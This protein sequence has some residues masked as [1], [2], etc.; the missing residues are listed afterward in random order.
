MN[1][2]AKERIIFM[3][4]PEMVLILDFGGQHSQLLARRVREFEVYC[5]VHPCNLSVEQ[6]KAMAPAGIILT[7]GPADA[8]SPA[9]P[10]FDLEILNLGV[11]VLGICYG[12]LL[13]AHLSGGRVEEGLA[14]E[15]G[16]ATLT[17]TAKSTLLEGVQEQSACWIS[18][19][20][21]VSSLPEP[22]VI[23]GRTDACIAAMENAEKRLYGV[24][25]HP[26]VSHTECGNTVIK[27]FLFGIC[28]LSGGWTMEKYAE[29]AI[30]EIRKTVGNGQ[31]LL[32]LS[33]G[34][35]SSVCAALVSKAVG[36]QLT[37]VFVDHGLMR[38]DEGDEVEEAF[39]GHF[40]L[41][42]L[43]A[44]EQAHFLS[45]LKGVSD[46]E[47]KRK[48]IGREFIRVFEKY[49]KQIGTVDFLC[50]G[51][52]YPDVIESGPGQAAVIK[53]HHNVG[54]LPDVVNFRE[55]IE[56]LR[57][58]FKDEVRKLGLALG[59]PE[60]LVWRQPFPGPGLAIR[61]MGEITED[62]LRIVRESDA[63]FRA[64]IAAAGLEKSIHQYFTVLT[65]TKT[66]GMMDNAR[67]FENVL[68]LRAV[69]TTDF[70]TADWVRIPYEVLDK[71]SSRIISEVPGTNRIV[72][73]ITSKP[74]ATIEWE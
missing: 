47:Q 37:C 29:T 13:I 65:E 6:V 3:K 18:H 24:Q 31:V 59:L 49:A 43:R 69:A 57:P 16:R 10:S 33:G 26:E 28:G 38:K 40:D 19:S 1:S 55:I 63:I 32:A 72:Y 8:T 14:Q 12:H 64:E 7:G 52:I 27:N 39:K 42:F 56:P 73:D 41:N 45:H 74:P 22:F 66:V 70:M 21:V 23:T 48:I 2:Y 34:V 25:F 9:A 36:K 4:K 51:T 30:E 53:S 17:P 50:Q 5:E 20:F 11:P 58:L 67:T 61:V 60:H 68:A 15:Y 71:V 46:P 54:G 44:N 62:K 35:D